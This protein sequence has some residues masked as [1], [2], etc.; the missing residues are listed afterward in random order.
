MQLPVLLSF[1][2]QLP[3]GSAH[4]VPIK[5]KCK[6]KP[7]TIPRIALVSAFSGEADRFIDEMRLND[8]KNKLD[9]CVNINGHRFSKGKLRGK[10][11]VVVLTNISIVN[12]TMVTQLT[13]D[14]FNVTKVI[15]SGIAGGVGGVG[16][17]DD[18]PS[19]P[20]E[21]PIGSVTIPK[22]WGFPQETYFN[23]TPEI[24]PCAF[25][26]GLQLNHVLQDPLQEAK[27]CNF[28]LGQASAAGEANQATVF[29]PDA[30]N[31]FLRNT[32]VSSARTPQFYLNQNNEQIIRQVPFPAALVNSTTDQDLKFWFLVDETMFWKA[33]QLNVK[34]LDCPQL[35]QTGNCAGTPINPPPQLIVGQNGVSAPTFVDNAR[36]R[37]FL[38]TTLNFDEQGNRNANTDV[39]VVDME[40]T[41]SAMVA[42]SNNVPFIAVRS[43]SDLAGGGEAAAATQI[44]TFFALAAENQARVVFALLNAL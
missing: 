12:A 44:G 2:F 32:N 38:A 11:V 13:L 20:N 9:G 40:T 7:D 33:S 14:K 30:K 5:G 29:Q 19:T 26:P 27:T 15:F 24:V 35:S 28:L 39:L 41:A 1:A 6:A 25:S 37:R 10:N 42:Y 21:T 22:R 17:N 8:G 4:A 43:V 31:A 18:D 36:Y 3:V 34:L 23:N 16:A